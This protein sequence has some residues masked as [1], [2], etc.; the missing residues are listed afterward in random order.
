MAKEPSKLPTGY[1]EPG[2]HDPST[3]STGVRVSSLG[4]IPT[5]PNPT[6]T[7]RSAAS[8]KVCL[9]D[10]SIR[11][12][13]SVTTMLHQLG[14]EPLE[15]RRAR[16]RVIMF[17]KI[18]HHVVEVSVHHLLHVINSRTRGS[19]AIKIRQISTRLDAY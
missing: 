4:S 13:R 3:P 15:H 12:P 6:P 9:S 19:M 17:Y 10:Y 16:N 8:S 18:Y 7:R 14:F 2:I 11:E 1:Q 5:T